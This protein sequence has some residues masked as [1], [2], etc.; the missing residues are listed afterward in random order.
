MGEYPQE[1]FEEIGKGTDAVDKMPEGRNTSIWHN[2][3]AKETMN[4]KN[5]G[6]SKLAISSFGENDAIA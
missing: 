3:T 6:T 4:R 5:I 1:A 2:N